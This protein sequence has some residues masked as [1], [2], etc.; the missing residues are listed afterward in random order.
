MKLM[1]HAVFP[2][3]FGNVPSIHEMQPTQMLVLLR[4]LSMMLQLISKRQ[5]LAL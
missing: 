2:A 4:I 3:M 5:H 1:P